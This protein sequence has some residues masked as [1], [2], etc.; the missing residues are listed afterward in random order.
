MLMMTTHG[1][2]FWCVLWLF[3]LSFSLVCRCLTSCLLFFRD[4]GV[5]FLLQGVGVSRSR[6]PASVSEHPSMGQAFHPPTQRTTLS[7]SSVLSCTLCPCYHRMC[8]IAKRLG[9]LRWLAH[10]AGQGYVFGASMSGRT[11]VSLET[12]H[13]EKHGWRKLTIVFP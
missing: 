8:V 12:A 4:Q 6:L 9:S 11:D 10:A 5:K 3:L 7:A 1:D 2:A 13:D